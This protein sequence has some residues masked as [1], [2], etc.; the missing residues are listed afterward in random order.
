MASSDV[1]LVLVL[2]VAGLAAVADL[3]LGRKR[4]ETV[5]RSHQAWWDRLG[6][7]SYARLIAQ[8]AAWMTGVPRGAQVAARWARSRRFVGW[9]VGTGLVSAATVAAGAALSVPNPTVVL[10][11]AMRYFA[12]PG[13]VASLLALS[14]GML[15]LGR[16]ARSSSL[17]AQLLHAVFL[18]AESALFW[19]L[20]VHA[21]TWL[22][23]QEKATPTVYGSEW[24]YAE[25]F[26][27]YV[28][29]PRGQSILL[30]T[31]LLIGL[32]PALYL[33]RLCLALGCK[34]MRPVLAPALIGLTN[35]FARTRAGAYALAAALVVILA[36][37]LRFGREGL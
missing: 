30:A 23:W 24:F 7:T 21:A 28:R 26:M 4:R 1:L 14:V 2:A 16:S 35:K 34:T 3:C 15:V 9:F 5:A 17:P 32:P 6:E 33:V 19:L 37:L 13:A 20:L 8:A 12:L 27:A 25:I 36:G 18:V 31:V 29:E 11:H 22:E 10:H